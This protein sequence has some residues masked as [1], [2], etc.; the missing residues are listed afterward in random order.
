VAQIFTATADTW[1]RTVLL[2]SAL[3]AVATGLIGGGLV[4]SSYVTRVGWT[5]HQPVPFSHKHH[6]GDDGIDC[7]Y[8]HT[9][10][11]ESSEAGMPSTHTCMTCH[12]QLWTGAAVLAPVR[13]S[14][15]TGQ[16]IRWNRVAETP[17]FVFFRH[18]I[19][20]ERGVPCVTCH[21]RVDRMPL[22]YRAQAFQMQWCLDCHRDPAPHLRPPEM[23]TRMDWS[24]WDASDAHEDYG[25][26]AVKALGIDAKRLDF[27]TVCHR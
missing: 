13:E 3:A 4:N 25:A 12:S 21:G 11:A 1:L 6:V 20:I 10:V 9:T 8:C 2:V 26:L 5:R 22:L 16:P 18:S 15:A 17:D 24:D 14:L 7:R 19:H 27:C 23:V